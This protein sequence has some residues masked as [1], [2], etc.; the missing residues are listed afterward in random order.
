MFIIVFFFFYKIKIYLVNEC[1]L[2]LCLHSTR[3]IPA[4]RVDNSRHVNGPRDL[5][6]PYAQVKGNNGASSAIAGAAVHH[7]GRCV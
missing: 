4:N 3:A 5:V 2:L 6:L 7:N 1:I